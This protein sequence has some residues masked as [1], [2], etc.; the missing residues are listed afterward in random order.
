MSEHKAVLSFRD[1]MAANM[2]HKAL[3]RNEMETLAKFQLNSKPL[4]SYLDPNAFVDF[5]TSD[6][7]VSKIFEIQ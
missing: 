3:Q 5:I 4:Y 2:A 1:Q 7:M 6:Y